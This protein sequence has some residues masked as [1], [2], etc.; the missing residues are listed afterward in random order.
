MIYLKNGWGEKLKFVL[1]T[2]ITDLTYNKNIMLEEAKKI[3]N[4]HGVYMQSKG[5]KLLR[6]NTE[7]MNSYDALTAE[8]VSR[9]LQ[10]KERPEDFPIKAVLLRGPKGNQIGFNYLFTDTKHFDWTPLSKFCPNIV[11][12]I[13]LLPYKHIGRV[14]I[15][16]VE[17]NEELHRHLDSI[18]RMDSETIERRNQHYLEFGIENPTI[19]VNC[20]ITLVLQDSGGINFFFNRSNEKINVKH[21]LYYFCPHMIHH[22]IDKAEDQRIIVRIEGNA[23][24]KMINFLQ[25]QALK[26][27]KEVIVI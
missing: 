27:E 10:K 2:P 15:Q 12:F 20:F 5:L 24:T 4:D 3:L 18:L 9:E 11:K 16:T 23:C 7:G 13:E 25:E 17:K 1:Y 8:K 19:D 14:N 6:P 21:E 22:S 26:N